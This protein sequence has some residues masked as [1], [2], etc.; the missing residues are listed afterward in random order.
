[1]T[2]NKDCQIESINDP[3]TTI[4]PTKY[5]LEKVK[6]KII[7]A[8]YTVEDFISFDRNNFEIDENNLKKIKNDTKRMK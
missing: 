3:M 2:K 4:I 7:E 5:N 1:M 6:Q 8:G